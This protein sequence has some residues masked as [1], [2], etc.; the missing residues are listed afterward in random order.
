M[1]ASDKSPSPVVSI[2]V[3]I[4]NVEKYL[5]K[6]IE[7]IL[8]QTFRDFELIL[9]DDGSPD[10]CP[11]I[12]DEYAAKDSRIVVIHQQNAGVSAARN[13]G[14]DGARGKYIGF[15]DPDDWIAPEMYEEMIAAMEQNDVPLA[16]CGYDYYSEDGKLDEKRCYQ[17]R[18]NEVISQKEL[19]SRFSD[20]PPSIRHGV[21]NKLFYNN[22]LHDLRFAEGIH[23][24]EDVL[25][26]NEYSCRIASAVVVHKPFYKNLVRTGSA[27]HGGLSIEALA[28]SFNI[29]AGMYRSIIERYPE[30]RNHSQAFLLDICLLKYNEARR[31]LTML[32]SERKTAAS[33]RLQEMKHFIRSTA[34]SALFN[35]EIYWKTRICYLICR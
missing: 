21:C 9:V 1:Q 10:R 24:S 34:L 30:L 14:L 12:C 23:S 13:A 16:I 17:L 33:L 7:S 29:H 18:D 3:P 31:K 11:A 25:F 6:C 26:L 4:Y 5:P 20:M 32:S 35:P 15:V 8:A 28:D 2:I 19:M 27:T 22:L